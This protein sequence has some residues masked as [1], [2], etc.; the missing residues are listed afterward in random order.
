MFASRSLPRRDLVTP[1][2]VE[3]PRSCAATWARCR[4]K[5]NLSA[6]FS[7]SRRASGVACIARFRWSEMVCIGIGCFDH[8]Q[9][10]PSIAGQTEQLRIVSA[11]FSLGQLF[12][13]V[14][15][16]SIC[17]GFGVMSFE[18]PNS[19]NAIAVIVSLVA[20]LLIFAKSNS[21]IFAG[22]LSLP[23]LCI[24]NWATFVVAFGYVFGDRDFASTMLGPIPRIVSWQSVMIQNPLPVPAV[25]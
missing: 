6:R 8:G 18:L 12:L 24:A 23:L 16:W 21:V 7:A 22:S 5:S 9:P 11:R 14:A 2:A 13:G 25:E 17:F 15:L 1:I 3:L 10:L 4:S 19:I 20:T